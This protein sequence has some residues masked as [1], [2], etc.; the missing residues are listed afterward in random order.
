MNLAKWIGL[1][2]FLIS[3]YILWRIRQVLLLLLVSVVLATVLG[4]FVQRLQ[5]SG[6]PHGGAVA[7]SATLF[8]VIV[9]S[10]VGPVVAPFIDELQAVYPPTA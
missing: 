5:R 6:M 3:L 2:A 10:F 9:I 7:L 4:R 8:L 1:F